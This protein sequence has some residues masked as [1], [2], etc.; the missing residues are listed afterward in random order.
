MFL[1]KYINNEDSVQKHNV[2]KNVNF[3]FY[4]W[5]R[6]QQTKILFFDEKSL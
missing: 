5:S 1:F 3:K 2:M 6:H 4:S